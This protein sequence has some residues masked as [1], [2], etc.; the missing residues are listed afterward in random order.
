A[1]VGN[2]LV[3]EVRHR[4]FI[5]AH[6]PPSLSAG[7]QRIRKNVVELQDG[8]APTG[9]HLCGKSGRIGPIQPECMRIKPVRLDYQWVSFS[10]DIIHRQIERS[11]H[12]PADSV[13][14]GDRF[15]FAQREAGET[16]IQIEQLYLP[17]CA[18][19]DSNHARR[20]IEVLIEEN[21]WHFWEA[22]F[23]CSANLFPLAASLAIE[24]S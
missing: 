6:N 23:G 12:R 20:A 22:L 18:R 24:H 10:W 7:D 17:P 5:R 9:Q 2:S 8:N 11:G 4:V 13:L 21:R 19:I 16:G 1:R 15:D 14:P 3:V